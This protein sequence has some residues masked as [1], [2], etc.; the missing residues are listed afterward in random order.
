MCKCVVVRLK[1]KKVG[2][3]K[4]RWTK[5]WLPTDES[6]RIV[7]LLDEQLANHTHTHTPYYYDDDDDREYIKIHL[8]KHYFEFKSNFD[9]NHHF[10]PRYGYWDADGVIGQWWCQC[11]VIHSLIYLV[12]ID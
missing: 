5:F 11:D 8:Q 4:E 9:H 7:E 2:L 12:E 3:A 1:S 6:G 10:K